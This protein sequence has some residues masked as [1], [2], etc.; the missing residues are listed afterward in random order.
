MRIAYYDE[1]GD[2][3]FPRYSSPLFVLSAIYMHHLHWKDNLEQLL[4]L[5]LQLRDKYG[6]P[7]K[8][9]M[10]AKQFLLNKN[11]YRTLGISD[12]D[13]ADIIG[14]Y[15]DVF[16]SLNWRIVNVCIDKPKLN[17]RGFQVLDW[18]LKLSVQRIEN[19]LNSGG[20]PNSRFM[21]VTD[22]GRV[23]KMRNTTRKIQ[24][25]NFI[26]SKIGLGPYRQ[27]VQRLIEDPLPKDSKDSYFIQA[28]DLVAFVVY[29]H[30]LRRTG[31][32]DYHGRMPREVDSRQVEDWLYRLTPKLNLE[33]APGDP[34][35]IKYHP[36]K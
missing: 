27:E 23:G 4:Y 14:T 12:Q 26:P 18:A 24:K 29:L 19:D 34:Y 7:V 20:K 5:R 28:A 36:T 6:L 9:E 30:S 10:H 33:A 21:V 8:L 31:A 15:C 13:R 17:A 2:D 35:G 22:P 1:S 25:I 16:A 32:G 3:G 11:P